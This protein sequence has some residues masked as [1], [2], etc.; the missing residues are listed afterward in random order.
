M[1]EKH[2][3]LDMAHLMGHVKDADYFEFPHVLVPGGKIYL[4]QPLKTGHSIL[5]QSVGVKLIDDHI[6]PVDLKFTKFMALELIAA[7][8]CV[9][10]FSWLAQ[11]IS[12]GQAPKGRMTNFLETMVLFIRDEVARPAIGGGHGHDDHGHDGH[13]HE[14]H[15]H[16]D[17]GHHDH[18]HHAHGKS[19]KPKHEADQFVPYLLTLFFFVLGCNLLGMLPWAGSAT[20]ALATTG[21]LAVITFGT[22]VFTGMS[23]LGPV[24]FWTGLVPHMDLPL[25]LAVLLKPMIFAIEVL[26][27]VIKHF[28]LAVRLLANMFAGHLVLAVIVAFIAA[29]AGQTIWYVV[30]PASVFG[31]TA[32]SMLELFVA[33][34]Q[35]YLFTFLSALFIG[36]AVHPH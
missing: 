24:G 9:V 2:D 18:G 22:V 6:E 7:F 16:D 32:L 29:T 26:G 5:P 1:A 14:G 35:A 23:K 25:V 3:A 21:A 33:F 4:P 34:L 13:G 30:T 20:G 8:I 12:G 31:A 10:L 28:I 36:S 19:H 17:H 27:L 11:R 15:G